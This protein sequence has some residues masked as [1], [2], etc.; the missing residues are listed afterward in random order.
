MGCDL[1]YVSVAEQF[2]GTKGESSV[3][4]LRGIRCFN[5]RLELDL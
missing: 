3:G 2:L 4:K 5:Y 1:I